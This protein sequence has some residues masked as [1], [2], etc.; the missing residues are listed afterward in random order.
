MAPSATAFVTGCA[1][2]RAYAAATDA[3]RPVAGDTAPGD[4]AGCPEIDLHG[5]AR[6][7]GIYRF[8]RK[9]GSASNSCA[10]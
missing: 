5:H 6:N 4:R 3:V 8:I 10:G 7:G 1:G 2:G 9:H